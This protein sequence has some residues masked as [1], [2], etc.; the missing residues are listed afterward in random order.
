M[1]TEF[2]YAASATGGLWALALVTRKEARVSHF[3]AQ[4]GGV[5]GMVSALL[6]GFAFPMAGALGILAVVSQMVTVSLAYR[7]IERVLNIP[8][9]L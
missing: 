8:P 6:A 9:R 5:S 3:L 1:I 2:A 4:V 7:E